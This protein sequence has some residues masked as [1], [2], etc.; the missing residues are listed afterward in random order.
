MADRSGQVVAL[1]AALNHPIRRSVLRLLRAGRS[2][3]AA[4]ARKETAPYTTPNAINHHLGILV[5]AGAL[6]REWGPKPKGDV[7]SYGAAANCEWVLAVLELTAAE[8]DL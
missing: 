5:S 6:I 3:T 1:I 4:E 2:A 7:Y 8:D